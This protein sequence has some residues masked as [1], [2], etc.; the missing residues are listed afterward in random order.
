[1]KEKREIKERDKRG[2]QLHQTKPRNVRAKKSRK[3][4]G[5][6]EGKYWSQKKLENRGV[7]GDQTKKCLRQKNHEEK[8]EG[9]SQGKH[10]S[11]NKKETG[12]EKSHD[13]ISVPSFNATLLGINTQFSIS[14]LT[15]DLTTSS[16]HCIK[17]AQG[18]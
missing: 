1:M 17:T 13:D 16:N 12:C 4:K 10:W 5:K 9:R 2:S 7:R 15:C 6:E 3:R 18:C 11:Q 8:R 14:E